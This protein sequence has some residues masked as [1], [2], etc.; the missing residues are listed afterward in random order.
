MGK[1]TKNG[2]SR[3][4]HDS[5]RL[6]A[7]NVPKRQPASTR[8]YKACR[9]LQSPKAIL[10]LLGLSYSQVGSEYARITGG[11]QMSRQAVYKALVKP[12]IS[13]DML[14]VLG[15]LI[16]NHLTRICGETIGID[17]IQNSP[18][19]VTPYRYCDDCRKMYAI[20][21]PD[22]KRCKKCRA[23]RAA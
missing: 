9:P 16:S 22:V 15:Q 13:D 4:S 19:R 1:M 3:L 17:I 12:W 18:M 10:D 11:R 6:R 2:H 5:P 7:H 21:R 20:D 14:L 8:A 23:R